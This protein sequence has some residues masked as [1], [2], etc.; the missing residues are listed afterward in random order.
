MNK[1]ERVG[2]E[3]EAYFLKVV[4]G[5]FLCQF[6]LDSLKM[7]ER[8]QLESARMKVKKKSYIYSI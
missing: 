6:A 3:R 2:V 1:E 7:P 4:K 5:G 8:F